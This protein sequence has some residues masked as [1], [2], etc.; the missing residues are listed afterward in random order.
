M[1]N[2]VLVLAD[3]Y[4]PVCEATGPVSSLKAIMNALSGDLEFYL[5]T[6]FKGKKI[7]QITSQVTSNIWIDR[8]EC[9][10]RYNKN[11]F[12]LLRTLFKSVLS[13]EYQTLYC[14]SFFSLYYSII[15]LA[16]NKS[17]RRRGIQ[18]IV[19]SPR[20]ELSKDALSIKPLRKKI[21][22]TLAKLVNLHD[23]ISWH[24]TSESEKKDLLEIFVDAKVIA[25]PNLI[26][27]DCDYKI[28]NSKFIGQAKLVFLSR[29][30]EIKN[31]LIVVKSLQ[32]V[33]SPVAFDIYGPVEDE[34]YWNECKALMK[35]LPDN[36]TCNYKGVV[37]KK[38]VRDVLSG[39]QLLVAP[40]RSENFG[41]V[42]VEAMSAGV[43]L[44]IGKN[45]PW[46]K[47]PL[48]DAGFVIDHEDPKEL[49]K[50]IDEYIGL[51]VSS[52]VNIANNVTKFF[53]EHVK[54]DHVASEI[55][56]LLMPKC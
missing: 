26:D 53:S 22:L 46:S 50:V 7:K 48:Y 54:N 31:L 13:S 49:A 42:L 15:P 36:V 3:Y 16:I 24:V 43:A 40:S 20:G 51:T 52:K 1:S 41:H 32:F 8:G 37:E 17:L 27:Y 56:N 9:F 19:V 33:S 38:C 12:D 55:S 39:Y 45:T 10:A 34:R 29:I 4:A 44:I 11:N 5:L 18:N 30:V 28:N 14:N 23:S 2:K 25:V 6:R 35:M 47:L 21:F